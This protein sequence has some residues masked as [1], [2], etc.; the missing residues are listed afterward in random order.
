MNKLI[1]LSVIAL[2]DNYYQ[3]TCGENSVHH[4]WENACTLCDINHRRVKKKKPR[5]RRKKK[6]ERQGERK[7]ERKA[8]RN[9]AR[10]DL[11]KVARMRLEAERDGRDEEEEEI[12]R[13][14]KIDE[15]MG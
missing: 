9:V 7:T 12:R 4:V 11:L 5:G 14:L 13:P 1:K 3:S 10:M 15:K 2:K 8:A 6:I